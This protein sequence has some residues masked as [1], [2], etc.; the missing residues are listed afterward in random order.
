MGRLVLAVAAVFGLVV[1]SPA[2]VVRETQLPKNVS[3]T[4]TEAFQAA[5]NL[6]HDEGVAIARR[7]I[8][9]APGESATHRTLAAML[10]VQILF[11]RG[12]VSIDHFL[13]GFSRSD[14]Q[15]PKPPAEIDAEFKKEI[16]QAIALAEARLKAAPDD[17]QAIFDVGAAHGLKASYTASIEGKV[18]SAFSAARRA[19]D[20]QEKVL[21]KDPA[22]TDAG[23]VVGVYRYLVASFRWP[24]RVVAYMAGFGGDKDRAIQL[25]EAAAKHPATRVDARTALMLI[26]S[27][28]GRHAEVERLARELR[29]LAPKNRLLFLEEGSA[30]IRAGNA[31]AAE[32]VL[33]RGLAVFA[34]D[35]RPKVPGERSLWLYKR[36]LARVNLN[37]LPD[38]SVDLR[39]ALT[40]EPQGWIR[41]RIHVELGKIEDL[42]GRRAT[43]LE[44]YKTAKTTC[45]TSKDPKC[46]DEAGRLIRRPFKFDKSGT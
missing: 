6:D 31:R 29:P 1:A 27:R 8:Q 43:A 11:K 9:M 14:I 40:A 2:Q 38:A 17:V 19:Y 13:G 28:E 3:D 26:S 18:G 7:A 32:E 42:G 22:R 36:G 44:H 5:Y 4:I 21:E 39:E 24:T 46:A 30:A 45:E 34:R 10:W 16:E 41:G 37:H 12:T 33:T 23:L 35:L 20:Q 15:M 25:L